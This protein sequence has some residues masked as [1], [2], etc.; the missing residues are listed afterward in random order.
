MA[1]RF[2]AVLLILLIPKISFASVKEMFLNEDYDEIV[3]ILKDKPL[4]ILDAD[5][6]YYLGYSYVMVG[7]YARGTELIKKSFFLSPS[8]EKGKV[9]IRLFYGLGKYRDVIAVYKELR[10]R[11]IELSGNLKILVIR[12]MIKEGENPD[13]LLSTF[14]NSEQV[15]ALSGLK[16]LKT[17]VSFTQ[18]YDSNILLLP[19]DL[20]AEPYS[21][22]GFVSEIDIG[23]T[24][25]FPSGYTGLKVYSL[26]QNDRNNDRFDFYMV[27]GFFGRKINRFTGTGEVYYVYTDKASYLLGADLG[28]AKPFLHSYFRWSGGYERNF[29]D[30]EK[31]AFVLK[32]LF[33]K[34][35]WNLFSEFK[36]YGDDVK[37]FKIKGE[38]KFKRK[39]G[40]A[41]FQG[42]PYLKVKFY[43]E[44]S[45]SAV[46]GVYMESIYRFKLVDFV[47]GVKFEKS[48]ADG[49]LENDYT[50]YV[51]S[52][53]LK[54]LF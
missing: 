50:R 31:S 8:T 32:G 15:A 7:E 29:A 36:W 45:K 27:R 48:F 46:P 38:I 6:L 18:K 17:V 30:V 20:D 12:S 53:G 41:V 21:I 34:S 24:F 19:E 43:S 39:I 51:L 37:R 13:E 11:G 2:I 4:E 44:G 14:E 33:E 40:K 47:C 23:T 1:K 10:K 9:L 54:K 26:V 28:F 42:F 16:M 22:S 3:G 5:S 25:F 52:A 35:S 49:N